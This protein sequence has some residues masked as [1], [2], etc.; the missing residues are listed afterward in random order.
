MP[1]KNKFKTERA[2]KVNG[3]KLFPRLLQVLYALVN[4]QEILIYL[5]HSLLY[6]IFPYSLY[7][8]GFFFFKL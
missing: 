5:T 4:K 8:K 3:V 7:L 6:L 2:R 1:S